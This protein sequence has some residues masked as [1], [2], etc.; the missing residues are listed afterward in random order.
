MAPLEKPQVVARSILSPA[1]ES[2]AAGNIK[3]SKKRT[4]DPIDG[5]VATI[6]A[7]ARALFDDPRATSVYSTRGLFWIDRGGGR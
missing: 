3:P 2:D 4:T 6:M 7:L 5:L 1:A